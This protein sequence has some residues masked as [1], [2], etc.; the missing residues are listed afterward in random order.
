MYSRP[1]HFLYRNM[2]QEA[3]CQQIKVPQSEECWGQH[4]NLGQED[5][6]HLNNLNCRLKDNYAEEK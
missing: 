2:P 3:G 1:V 4:I 5:P 6:A